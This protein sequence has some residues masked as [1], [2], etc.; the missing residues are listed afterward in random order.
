MCTGAWIL[1]V[2]SGVGIHSLRE[3]KLL[4]HLRNR[5]GLSSI[6]LFLGLLSLRGIDPLLVLL[7][8]CTFMLGIVVSIIISRSGGY[9]RR[10][11]GCLGA[12]NGRRGIDPMWVVITSRCVSSKRMLGR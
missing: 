6:G 11:W 2:G 4:L 9:H 5:L 7:R 1:T 3:G 12:L 10:W 8:I